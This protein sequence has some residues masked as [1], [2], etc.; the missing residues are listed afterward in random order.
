MRR[1]LPRS[2]AHPG[3]RSGFGEVAVR[4]RDELPVEPMTEDEFHE[5]C[6]ATTRAEFV[7]G[8]V[9]LFP[10]LHVRYADVRGFL[11]RLIDLYLEFRPSGKLLGTPYQIR[12][13]PGLRRTPDLFYLTP[14]H[15]A[16]LSEHYYCGAPDVVWEIVPE[17]GREQDRRQRFLDYEQAG[18][19]EY[20]LIDRE[21]RSVRVYQRG[22]TG[23][24][25]RVPAS[26]GRL[27]SS[28]IPG[29]WIRTD[30]LWQQPP[31]MTMDCLREMGVV[32]GSQG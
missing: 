4:T 32:A 17:G 21:A 14:Q 3:E 19:A 29:F 30:W 11:L 28:V 15:E 13:R 22:E 10:P 26:G 9:V 7:D 8:R 18:V 12:L 24:Y 23:E 20:W 16:Q 5:W 1:C 31:P 6:D 2:V 27:D 25:R